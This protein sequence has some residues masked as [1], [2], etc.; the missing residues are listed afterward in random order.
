MTVLVLCM[1][2]RVL[3]VVIGVVVVA[4][5]VDSGGVAVIEQGFPELVV[6]LKRNMIQNLEI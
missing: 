6:D 5:S 2:L 4:L 1:Y 3:L